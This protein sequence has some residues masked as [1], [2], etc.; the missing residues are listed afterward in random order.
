M[1]YNGDMKRLKMT[2]DYA[3][4]VEQ[5]HK[6]FGKGSLPTEFKFYYMDEDNEMI[7][8]NSQADFEEALSIEDF[9]ALK[10]TVAGSTKAA[11]AQLCQKMSDTQSMR[12]SLNQSGL[13]APPVQSPFGRGFSGLELQSMPS[14]DQLL[15]ERA[16]V[17][18]SAFQDDF[19]NIESSDKVVSAKIVE[20]VEEKKAEEPAAEAD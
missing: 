13:F 12:E 15:T 19:E 10:L 18:R 11:Q 16:P 5:T 1:C 3:S 14:T 8:I 6:A 7:S 9:G 4:L 17:M 2:Q 20:P